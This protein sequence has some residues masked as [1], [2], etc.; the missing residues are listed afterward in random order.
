MAIWTAFI[1]LLQSVL[2]AATQVCGGNLGV[3]IIASGLTLRLA[4]FPLTYRMARESRRRALLMSKLQPEIARLRKRH[5]ENPGALVTAQAELFRR[6]GVKLFD[7]RSLLGGVVQMP[8]ALGMYTV[9][10]R[11][12]SVANPGR[13]LWIPNIGRPDVLLAIGVSLLTYAMVSLGAHVGPQASRAML[14]IPALVTLLALLKFSAGLGLYWG[15]SSAVGVVQGI[16]L[17]RAR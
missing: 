5:K 10:R 9:V 16:L 15:A 13:F 14:V 12:L 6:R 11:A 1:E 8:F 17:R 3:G 4:L 2:F 7:G